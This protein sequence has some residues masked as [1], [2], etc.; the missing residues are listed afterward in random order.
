MAPR[1]LG[2]RNR[3][4]DPWHQAWEARPR[5]GSPRVMRQ[6]SRTQMARVAGITRDWED[7]GHLLMG[8][9]GE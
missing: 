5:T 8:R 2:E 6:L 1:A 3:A 7:L 4:Q 9:A